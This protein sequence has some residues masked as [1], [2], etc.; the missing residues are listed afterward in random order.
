M[1]WGEG[2]G[3]E[4]IQC[5]PELRGSGQPRHRVPVHGWETLAL[6]KDGSWK[7][8]KDPGELRKVLDT[9]SL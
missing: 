4:L 9:D 6:T 5:L 3:R 1:G 8:V 2:G 7:R